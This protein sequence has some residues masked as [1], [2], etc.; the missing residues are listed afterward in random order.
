MKTKVVLP[1]QKI[2][3][4]TQGHRNASHHRYTD[5]VGGKSYR[6]GSEVC[7]RI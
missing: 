1:L 3:I 4:D 7:A 6:I 2:Q 5:Q